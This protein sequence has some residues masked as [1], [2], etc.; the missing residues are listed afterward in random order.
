MKHLDH[1]IVIINDKWDEVNESIRSKNQRR[2]T[3]LQEV[4]NH[5]KEGE[6]K[7]TGQLC[8]SSYFQKL[9]PA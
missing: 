4:S 1:I 6:E 5:V 8:K 7:A 9:G 3:R 2:D